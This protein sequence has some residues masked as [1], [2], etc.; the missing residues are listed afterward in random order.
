[1]TRSC[2]DKPG[3]PRFDDQL[4]GL[5][6]LWGGSAP[7]AHFPDPQALWLLMRRNLL[8]LGVVSVATASLAL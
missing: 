2:E 8:R 3:R 1:M 7:R 6:E 5:L 4:G